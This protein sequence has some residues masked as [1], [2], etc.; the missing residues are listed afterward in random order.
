MT[1]YTQDNSLRAC[2]QV[3]ILLLSF[4]HADVLAYLFYSIWENIH[5][6]Q[7]SICMSVGVTVRRRR[8]DGRLAKTLVDHYFLPKPQLQPSNAWYTCN[9]SPHR[10]LAMSVHYFWRYEHFSERHFHFRHSDFV[11][12]VMWRVG[13]A[14]Y[15]INRIVIIFSSS[16]SSYYISHKLWPPKMKMTHRNALVSIFFAQFFENQDIWATPLVS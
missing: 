16:Y 2:R 6:F 13:G 5:Q 10:V 12:D 1:L 7:V 9:L 11:A 14:E 8:L 3:C 15:C 4:W